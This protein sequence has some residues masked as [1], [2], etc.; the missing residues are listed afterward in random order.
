MTSSMCIDILVNPTSL[1]SKQSTDANKNAIT[2]NK[3]KRDN[4]KENDSMND[5]LSFLFR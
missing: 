3:K 4:I 1:K 2:D 5:I